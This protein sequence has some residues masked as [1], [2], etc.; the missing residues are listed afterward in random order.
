MTKIIPEYIKNHLV[1]DDL[2]SSLPLLRFIDEQKQVTQAN[3]A[4]AIG[5]ARGTCNLHFQK[6]EHMGLIRRAKSLQPNGRGRSTIVWEAARDKNFFILIIFIPPFFEGTLVDFSGKTVFYQKH[7]LTHTH[8]TENLLEKVQHFCNA[9]LVEAH[10]IGG[11]VR[12]G[13]ISTPGLINPTTKTIIKSYNLPALNDINFP[14]WFQ[15]QYNLPCICESIGLPLYFGETLA[16]PEGTRTMVVLWGM[17][18]GVIAGES[19]RI[20]SPASRMFLSSFG[21]VRI[22]KDGRECQH[23]KKGSLEA[24]TGGFAIIEMLQDPGIQTL[25]DLTDAVLAGN[26]TAIQTTCSAA[27]TIGENLCMPLQMMKTQR[28]IIGG[29]LSILFPVVRDSFFEGLSTVFE[30]EEISALNPTASQDYEQAL[31]NGA[32]IYAHQQFLYPEPEIPVSSP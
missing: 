23:A 9:A 22:Q 13:F 2:T 1:L 25:K 4:T 15:D 16:I 6:L 20:V 29:P 18:V 3:A 30:K 17:G 27:R 24:H 5:L 8:N 19:P 11:I 28:L 26:A 32:Y 12:L 14:N 21:D 7:D 10:K 31:Q